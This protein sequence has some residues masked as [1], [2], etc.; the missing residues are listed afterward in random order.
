MRCYD[1]SILL[2]SRMKHNAGLMERV[3]LMGKI[4]STLCKLPTLELMF[5]NFFGEHRSD[6]WLSQIPAV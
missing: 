4:D 5:Y 1:N 2:N 3:H 6:E